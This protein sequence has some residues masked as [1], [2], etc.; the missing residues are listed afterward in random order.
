MTSEIHPAVFASPV[1][2]PGRTWPSGSR[3][4]VIQFSIFAATVLAVIG[5]LLPI[6]YQSFIDR[7]L[8]AAD[9]QLTLQNY[10]NLSA[11][12]TFL[13]MV[14]NTVGFAA[15]STLVAQIAGVAF[16]VLVGRTD[17]P[18]RGLVGSLVL[19]P[20]FLSPLL[21]SMGWFILYGPAGYISMLV[22][23]TLGSSLWNLYSLI[24]MSLVA[25]VAQ[26]PVTVLYCLSSAALAD[27]RM[28]D[29]ARSVGAGPWRTLRHVTLPMLTPA[30]LFSGV[31][32][33][34][35]AL[36]SLSI[37]LIFGQPA[38]IK[39]FMTY[40]YDEA[41][42]GT[43][44]NY[45]I[46]GASAT[47]LLVVIAALIWL[48]KKLLG[49]P[50]RFNSVSGK[51]GRVSILRL[52]GWRWPAFGIA[53]A[54]LIF[55]VLLPL[56][57]VVLRAFVP[58][59]SPLVS[60]W[61]ML[62]LNN[63]QPLLT[64]TA[65]LRPITNTILIALIAAVLGTAFTGLVGLVATRSAFRQRRMLEYVALFP[66]AVPGMIAGIGI[67][68]IL[69][70][71]PAVGWLRNSIWII[72]LAYVA[73]ALPTGLGAISPALTKISPDLDRAVRVAGGDWWTSMRVAVF[74]LMTPALFASFALMFI[75]FTKEYS[76]AIFLVAPGSE[77]LGVSILQAWNQ[78]AAGMA[79]AL[80]TVQ[81]ALLVVFLIVAQKV[82]K[83]KIY[84]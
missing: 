27:S 12:P 40:I 1:A 42:A 55:L 39:L 66:R 62:S 46:I 48:Q 6:F 7:P 78:G 79:S 50:R 25:G 64:S 44:P 37:P 38:G 80:A 34:M 51:A 47:V 71:V 5:P 63:F 33:F 75:A 76:T 36:E 73:R 56:G 30:I 52:A 59:L 65:S 2:N 41:F 10:V 70:F 69:L 68:Y 19:W 60:F 67:L 77:V 26:A 16:A 8:Y 83:V 15:L 74:K 13:R 43:R 57:A 82:L 14:L 61:S 32:N 20:L 53:M 28:E 21:L 29:A 72:I 84:G 24:G 22:M 3:S 23:T 45:G 4:Q 49:D 35:N 17:M 11:D 31:L 9:Q 54:Y 58:F 18:G 81:M